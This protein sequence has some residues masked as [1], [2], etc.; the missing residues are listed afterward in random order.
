M[1]LFSDLS[2]SHCCV[3]ECVLVADL[4]LCQGIFINL[5]TLDLSPNQVGDKQATVLSQAHFIVLTIQ[6]EQISRYKLRLT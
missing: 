6:F 5:N 4:L 1:H 3:R 2:K